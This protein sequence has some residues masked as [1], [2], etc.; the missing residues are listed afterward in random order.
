[1][2]ALPEACSEAGLLLTCNAASFF[3]THFKRKLGG[4]GGMSKNKKHK[5]TE[6]FA[7]RKSS[8]TGH[9]A[10]RQ[11]SALAALLLLRPQR[12]QAV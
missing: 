7:L 11:N 1:M 8:H 12:A 3:N 4:K 2:R 10:N 9:A 5:V 6:G